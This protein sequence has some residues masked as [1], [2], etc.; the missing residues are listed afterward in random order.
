MTAR[1]PRKTLPSNEVGGIHPAHQYNIVAQHEYETSCLAVIVPHSLVFLLMHLEVIKVS[2]GMLEPLKV[3]LTIPIQVLPRWIDLIW[4]AFIG[5][6][7][8][9][10]Q[11]ED[12]R[13]I[14]KR[15][16]GR[17]WS[18]VSLI[19]LASNHNLTINQ[20]WESWYMRLGVIPPDRYRDES[21]SLHPNNGKKDLLPR[22]TSWWIASSFCGSKIPIFV[23]TFEGLGFKCEDRIIFRREVIHWKNRKR[24]W[25][26]K[27]E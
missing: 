16:L 5:R 21:D 22:V 11:L 24:Q 19:L 10:I 8:T 12:L 9:E 6:R 25:E 4:K 3:V 23:L 18:Y 2:I 14:L 17:S 27:W 7:S 20:G 26:K 13:F 1:K 15:I